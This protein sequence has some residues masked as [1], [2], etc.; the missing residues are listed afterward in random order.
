MLKLIADL[1]PTQ[2]ERETAAAERWVAADLDRGAYLIRYT[3]P[4]T[5]AGEPYTP[6]FKLMIPAAP[7]PGGTLAD[8]QADTGLYHWRAI[9]DDDAAAAVTAA[10][11][12]LTEWFTE[13]T[14]QDR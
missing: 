12:K 9:L 14:E 5:V 8:L 4:L 6:W 11:K 3:K 10:E 2:A 1:N 13:E 7:W